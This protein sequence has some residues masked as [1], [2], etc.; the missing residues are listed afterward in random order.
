M[1]LRID[2][3]GR[4]VLPE[5]VRNSLNLH[6]GDALNLQ[7]EGGRIVLEPVPVSEMSSEGQLKEVQGMLVWTGAIDSSTDLLEQAREDRMRHILGS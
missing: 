2:Q 7:L 4:V 1:T 6:E 5:Q 3:L